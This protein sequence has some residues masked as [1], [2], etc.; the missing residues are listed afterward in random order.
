M[1]A[2]ITATR[3]SMGTLPDSIASAEPFRARLKQFFVDGAS[4]DGTFE[5]L[6][7]VATDSSNVIVR[8]QQGSGLY[9]ALNEG[10]NAAISDPDVSCIGMLHSDDR[11]IPDNFSKFL[12][13]VETENA[14]VF[15]S[16]IQFHNS[17]DRVVRTWKS[18][19]YTKF[20]LNT[21]WM[22]PHTSMIVRN[23]VYQDAGLYRTDFGTAAD[24]EWIV[25]VMTGF[26]ESSCYYPAPTLSMRVGG[27]SG[28]SVQ[29]RLHANAMDGKVWAER[30]R[31]QSAVVRICK[32]ARKIG[33]FLFR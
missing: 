19:K 10:V 4:S 14:D 25:R 26:G 22:P 8:Q 20:K 3:D 18:G 12:A 30:S 1:L 17:V 23:R 9:G 31:L 13:H 16:D 2:L 11:L 5:Y 32:P 6:R 28:A 15:Y 21:G 27:A 24:Y 29:A 7:R 33:Q